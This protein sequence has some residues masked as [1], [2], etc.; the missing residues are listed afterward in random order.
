MRKEKSNFEAF[1]QNNKTE[2]IL[3]GIG[4]TTTLPEIELAAISLIPLV[5]TKEEYR[6]RRHCEHPR[7]S[8]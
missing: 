1:C 7:C 3:V 5:R 6:K 2:Q 8:K 4:K